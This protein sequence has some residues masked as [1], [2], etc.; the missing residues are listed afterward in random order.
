MGA[1]IR[2]LRMEQGLSLRDFGKQAC[3]HPFHVMAIKL[4]QLATNIKVL[5]AIAKA[6]G[7]ASLDLLNCDTAN[8][9]IGHL[10]ELIRNRPDCVRKVMLKVR[11][12]VEN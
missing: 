3:V 1:R 4:G 9:D 12:I 10:V 6:L 5:R 8:D 7:I 2:K 11:P